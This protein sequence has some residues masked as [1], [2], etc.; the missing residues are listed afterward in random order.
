MYWKPSLLED[1][2]GTTEYQ[3]ELATHVERFL[4]QSRHNAKSCSLEGDWKASLFN[5][6]RDLTQGNVQCHTSEKREFVGRVWST[7]LRR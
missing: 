5:L 6:L 4:D 2:I 1:A 7:I 3:S